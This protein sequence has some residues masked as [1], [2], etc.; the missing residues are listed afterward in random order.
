MCPT[1]LVQCAPPSVRRYSN[2]LKEQQDS[3]PDTK[4]PPLPLS[5]P[6]SQQKLAPVQHN[7]EAATASS[8]GK[9]ANGAA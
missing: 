3:G 7:G 9:M 6:G 2:A 4:Q 1:L 5:G 8:Y